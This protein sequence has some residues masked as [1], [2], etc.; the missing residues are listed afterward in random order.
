MGCLDR[1]FGRS[2][3]RYRKR[4]G[5]RAQTVND[6][7]TIGDNQFAHIGSAV[8]GDRE[9]GAAQGNGFVNR[10]P[11]GV[12]A[13]ISGCRH[14]QTV[15]A[16]QAGRCRADQ[17]VTV[18]TGSILPD[19]E[20]QLTAGQGNTANVGGGVVQTDQ[21]AVGGFFNGEIAGNGAKAVDGQIHPG[22]RKGQIIARESGRQGAAGRQAAK[23]RNHHIAGNRAG[24]RARFQIKGACAVFNRDLCATGGDRNCHILR[25]DVPDPITVIVL[26]QNND[27]ITTQP[28]RAE[29]NIAADR[30]FPAAIRHIQNG[31]FCRILRRQ[32]ERLS[33][34]API[35]DTGTRILNQ[36][37]CGRQL[38]VQ[39]QLRTVDA[40][41]L[42][43]QNRNATDGTRGRQPPLVRITGVLRQ[44]Q[45]Q[46]TT[47]KGCVGRSALRVS[48]RQV[49]AADDRLVKRDR[50]GRAA[51]VDKLTCD[52]LAHLDKQIPRK[53]QPR[54]LRRGLTGN[55]GFV[56]QQVD[57]VIAC[58]R[59]HGQ[60][61]NRLTQAVV[62]DLHVGGRQAHA[63]GARQG[64]A[65]GVRQGHV[66]FQLYGI[67]ARSAA[68]LVEHDRTATIGQA[69][70]QGTQIQIAARV[71]QTDLGRD[72]RFACVVDSG[73][74][75]DRDGARNTA[76]TVH[77]NRCRPNRQLLH[78]GNGIKRDINAANRLRN[79]L[80]QGV[81]ADF[82]I[83]RAGRNACKTAERNITLGNQCVTCAVLAPRGDVKAKL[84]VVHCKACAR[85]AHIGTNV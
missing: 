38:L 62:V 58:A 34:I 47:T 24:V 64:L 16:R 75:A 66:A 5:D 63:F 82:R 11:K 56:V 3:R 41:D 42:L 77:G 51:A 68:H 67:G 30:N 79:G 48:D 32:S 55:P 57:R 76:Q 8:E 18:S 21:Q 59:V 1:T 36:I 70:A 17:G 65:F 72:N 23:A 84:A 12:D 49:A 44:H 25:G 73:L 71:G 9:I 15:Q 83:R 31:G 69:C 35:D 33:V 40:G 39:H 46:I 6:Q 22:A 19:V 74:V 2:F 45:G 53:G 50:R 29:I 80:L 52:V 4:T 20:T 26:I 85:R 81:Y 78:V 37:A 28:R 10:L 27:E 61:L 7:S 43:L 54:D 60:T 13:D 14:G